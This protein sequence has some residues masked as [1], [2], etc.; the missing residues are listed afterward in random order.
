M[1]VDKKGNQHEQVYK[2]KLELSLDPKDE[3]ESVSKAR[4]V[5]K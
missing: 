5:E 1:G 4:G 3:E 2:M